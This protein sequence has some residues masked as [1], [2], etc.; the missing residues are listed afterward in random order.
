MMLRKSV[1]VLALFLLLGISLHPE[2]TVY[3][4]DSALNVELLAPKRVDGVPGIDQTIRAKITNSSDI[5]IS[6]VM[7]YITMADLGKHMTVNLED[8]GADKPV[9][10]GTLSPHESKTVELPV[11]FVYISHYLLYV[12]AVSSQLEGIQSSLS[13]PVAIIG[14]STM[15]PALANIVTFGMPV[16]VLLLIGGLYIWRKRQRGRV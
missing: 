9:L 14:N 5:T 15:D 11:R 1:V 13:I 6:D 12:T 4:G 8:Y 7:T 2:P 16:V 10:I 3:A